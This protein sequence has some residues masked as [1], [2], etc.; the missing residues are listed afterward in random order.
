MGTSDLTRMALAMEV[1]FLAFGWAFWAYWRERQRSRALAEVVTAQAEFIAAQVLAEGSPV[2]EFR[3]T[4]RA[5]SESDG[6]QSRRAD[7]TSSA[8]STSA[9]KPERKGDF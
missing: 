5:V 2:S 8:D 7:T 3:Q 4:D 9:L 6:S 1:A